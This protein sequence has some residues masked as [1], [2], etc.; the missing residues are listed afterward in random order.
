MADDI[1]GAAKRSKATELLEVLEKVLT[2]AEKVRDLAGDVEIGLFGSSDAKSAE[3]DVA[4]KAVAA[5]LIGDTVSA[6]WIA[7][8]NLDVAESALR[9]IQNELTLK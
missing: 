8:R 4:E 9:R 5:G 6:L 1:D 2:R 3:K 7:A